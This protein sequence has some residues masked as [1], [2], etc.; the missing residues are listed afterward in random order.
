MPTP[1]P[2]S[3]LLRVYIALLAWW[4]TCWFGADL[5]TDR[6]NRVAIQT[7]SKHAESLAIDVA[8]GFKRI[9]AVRTGMPRLLAGDP[10]L[11]RT[12]GRFGP[13][14]QPSTLDAAE[15]QRRWTADPELAAARQ[16]LQDAAN[17]LGLDA[18]WLL[19]AAGD[20]IAASNFDSAKNLTGANHADREYFLAAHQGQ[21]GHKLMSGHRTGAPG[22]SFYAPVI[23]KGRFIGAIVGAVDLATFGNWLASSNALVADRYG[24]IL[25]A[26]DPDLAFH[27]LPGA[28]ALQLSAAERRKLYGR[29]DIPVLE[30]R[31]WQDGRYPGLMVLPTSSQPIIMHR[32]PGAGEPAAIVLQPVD[33]IRNNDTLRLLIFG[34]FGLIGSLAGLLGF[35]A[36]RHLRALAAREQE[37]RS[38][39]ESSPD[40][41]IRYDRE[42]RMRYIN[43][44][45]LRRFDLP[46]ADNLIGKR[47]FEAWPDGRYQVIDDAIAKAMES[48]NAT[49]I[50]YDAAADVGAPS[51]ARIIVVPERD[52]A[53]AIIGAIAFGHDITESKI[54][55]SAIRELNARLSATLLAIPDILIETDRQGV[56]LDIWTRN[57]G[58]L[59]TQREHLLGRSAQEVLPSDAAEVAMAAIREADETGLSRGK[60]MRLHVADGERWFELSV[61]KNSGESDADAR[62]IGL[63]RDITDRKRTE[64]ALRFIA[65]RG[66][67]GHGA[68]SFLEALARFVGETLGVDYVIINRLTDEPEIAETAALYAKGDMAPSM[69]YSLKDT[70]CDNVM[71]KTLCVYRAGIQAQFPADT[72]LFH[73]GVESYA[74]IPLWDSAGKPIGLIAILHGKPIDNEDTIVTLLQLVATRAAAE[75][76]HERDD[77]LLRLREEEFR[78][79]AENSPDV[80][81]RFDSKCRR[82]YVNPAGSLLA[83]TP[84]EALL[85]T[86]PADE[87]ILTANHGEKL[88]ASIHRVFATGKREHLDLAVIFPDGSSH[89][90]DA[91]VVPEF[92]P[93]GRVTSVLNLARDITAHRRMEA[94]LRNEAALRETL[95]NALCDAGLQLMVIENSRVIHVGNREL[96]YRI[97]YTDAELDNHPALLDFIH[98]DDRARVADY[99][100]RRLAGEDVPSR[101]ELGLITHAGE[102]VE[103][104]TAVAVV[105]NS[106]PVRTVTIAWEIS[107][108]KRME[109]ELRRREQEFRSLAESSPDFV[110]RYDIE[111]RIRYLNDSLVRR[112]GLA[113]AS[114]VIGKRPI[115]VWPDGRFAVIDEATAQAVKAEERS[116]IELTETTE[117]GEILHSHIYIVPERDVSGQI[118]GAIAFGRDITAIRE[119]ERRLHH[120]VE[121]L[122][123][124]AYIFRRSPDG[125]I[126]FPFASPGITDLFGLQPEDVKDDATPIYTLAHPD[127]LPLIHAATAESERTLSPFRMESRVC[128]PGRPESWIELRS[129]PRKE[130][131]G[132][133]LWYGIMLD[134]TERKLAERQL[135]QAKAFTEGVINAIPDPVFVKDRQHVWITLNDAFCAMIGRSR[136][137]L[138]GKSDYDFF[139]PEQA[140][141]FWDKDELVFASRRENLNEELFTD[142]EGIERCIQTKKTVVCSSD[143]VD[144]LIGTIRDITERKR[145]ERLLTDKHRRLLADAQR[146]AQVGSWELDLSSGHID[147]SDEICRLI[148]IDPTLCRPAIETFLATVHPDDQARVRQAYADPVGPQTPLELDY[149]LAFP[150]GRIKHVRERRAILSGDDGA[151]I[152]VSAALQDITATRELARRLEESHA[153]LEELTRH[154]EDLIEEERRRIARDLHENLGQLL[155]SLRMGIGMLR[156]RF[157]AERD[158]PLH[159]ALPPLLSSVDLAIDGMRR[160]VTALRPTALDHGIDAALQTLAQDFSA[161]TGVECNVD[162]HD[163]ATEVSNARATAIF[164]IVQEAL[165]NVARHAG[166]CRVDIRL[167]HMEDQWQLAVEDDGCGFA[168]QVPRPKSFGLLGMDERARML[169]G[170]LTIESAPGRGTIV[171]VRFPVV[172]SA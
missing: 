22:I 26:Y 7:E 105:P 135:L 119:A 43:S 9:V 75:L 96:A 125:R 134:I 130:A 28:S 35:S 27:A 169:G 50:E 158:K 59:A 40:F 99:H 160:A 15:R 162:F 82:T 52:V 84:P 167:Q 19:N 93:D 132:S 122:P 144:I 140:K 30:L 171:S 133:M 23:D 66:W 112:L 126:S 110:I 36:L 165:A 20:C 34:A 53:G 47:P 67:T 49:T 86:T 151:P 5:F 42:H 146:I 108:R 41:V 72:L 54:A 57:P 116:V 25:L 46:N 17:D 170:V 124:M 154:R 85:G 172:E 102:R 139:P 24:V 143:G 8:T 157:R 138:I 163:G 18:F 121:N 94:E 21:S 4:L 164:R 90:Y 78:S 6:Q 168:P 64:D 33:D 149:R 145:L 137:T 161:Q 89:E 104:E 142:G 29:D 73:M 81:V 55:N 58:L 31:P 152:H 71:G 48:G 129:T 131:D 62:F 127:E 68:T 141:V 101:Y 166:A 44:A 147:W 106:S 80:I 156:V 98:P 153:Q 83:G 70:P 2:S 56:Y 65:Q 117:T 11:R 77:R 12:L 51:Y 148:E 61:A 159:D 91:L 60:V 111:H 115:E 136:E 38:L 128:R 76:E 95:L 39:A 120:F 37:F 100:H 97:G 32:Q 10:S 109:A 113:S 13:D 16:R 79:L 74:G 150:D 14:I 118:I 69:R 3:S 92:G 123:G 114:E 88:I 63:S 1:N 87:K 45:L 107:D 103:F 155:G